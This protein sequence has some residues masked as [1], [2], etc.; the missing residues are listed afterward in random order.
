MLN[1]FED[2][3]LLDHCRDSPHPAMGR[4]DLQS[5]AVKADWMQD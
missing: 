3:R 4:A 2:I 5:Q 1:S